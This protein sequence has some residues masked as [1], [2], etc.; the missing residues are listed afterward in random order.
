[1]PIIGAVSQ[2]VRLGKLP[3]SLQLGGKYYADSPP[4]GPEWGVRFTFT[5]LLPR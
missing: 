5:I 4:G 1:M 3:V 2:V